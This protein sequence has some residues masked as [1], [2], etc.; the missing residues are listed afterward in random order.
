VALKAFE[1]RKYL[2]S[3]KAGLALASRSGAQ[4]EVDDAGLMLSMSTETNPAWVRPLAAGNIKGSGQCRAPVSQRAFAE[5]KAQ[6]VRG[7]TSFSDRTK[8]SMEAAVLAN[9]TGF[10]T[11]RGERCGGRQI[12]DPGFRHSV[13]FDPSG[14]L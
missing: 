6:D 8:L 14:D 13:A 4:G 1:Y 12:D 9:A 7:V 10:R 3:V 2:A 5:K 11:G